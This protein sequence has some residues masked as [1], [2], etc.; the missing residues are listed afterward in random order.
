MSFDVSPEFCLFLVPFA[1]SMLRPL[2]C[3]MHFIKRY[4]ILKPDKGSS[5]SY[6]VGCGVWRVSFATCIVVFCVLFA[7]G[8]TTPLSFC[9]SFG[10]VQWDC[11]SFHS[12]LWRRRLRPVC[13]M[14]RVLFV[15]I[16]CLCLV[17]V[18]LLVPFVFGENFCVM[19]ES[20]SLSRPSGGEKETNG[21]VP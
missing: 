10:S 6:V 20:C 15:G 12:G 17:R 18:M 21:R 9:C 13:V 11:G 7:F 5:P 16:E 4:W 2:V 19:F 1:F 14:F 3:T 8:H